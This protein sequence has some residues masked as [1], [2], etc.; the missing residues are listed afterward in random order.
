MKEL[1][2]SK[3]F[4]TAL[5]GGVAAFV[6]AMFDVESDKILAILTPFIAYIAAQGIADHGKEAA[7]IHSNDKVE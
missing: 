4:I 5:I 3:K 2:T 7:K 6:S 1:F